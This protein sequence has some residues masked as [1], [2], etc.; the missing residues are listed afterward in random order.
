M[1]MICTCV[2]TRKVVGI[3]WIPETTGRK[4]RC[5]HTLPSCLMH[6]TGCC[7][8]LSC[9]WVADAPGQLPVQTE[10]FTM[11]LRTYLTCTTLMGIWSAFWVLWCKYNLVCSHMGCLRRWHQNELI[12][13]EF[14][15]SVYNSFWFLSMGAVGDFTC[16]NGCGFLVP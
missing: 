3:I 10:N 5:V 6:S 12:K 15:W 13:T 14:S 7:T 4:D 8:G 2:E 9:L 11:I 1:P 16:H